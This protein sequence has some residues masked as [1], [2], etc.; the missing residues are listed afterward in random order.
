MEYYKAE[1]NSRWLC[2]CSCEV[3]L[4]NNQAAAKVAV[5]H[6]HFVDQF[7]LFLPLVMSQAATG[8]DT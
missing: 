2:T 5:R 7:E 8:K 4:S 3:Q 1:P 6:L